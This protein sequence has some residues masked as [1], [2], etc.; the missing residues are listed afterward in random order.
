MQFPNIDPIA[1][2]LGPVSIHWYGLM[3]LVG[4]SVA[5]WLG[6]NRAKKKPQLGWTEDNVSDAIFYAAMGVI[7]GGRVGYML[8]YNFDGLLANPLSLFKLWEGGMSFH[9]GLIAC[10][11]LMWYFGHK[12]GKSFLQVT[13][14]MV[15]LGPIGIGAVRIANFINGELWGRTSD[16]P[17]AMV[18]PTGGPLAR[19]P[20]Q[21]YE[22]LLEG[23]LLFVV[24]WWF[25]GKQRPVGAASGLFLLWYGSARFII[26]F[27]RQPDAHMG[28]GGFMAMQWLTMGQI[29]STPMILFGAWLIW[30]AYQNAANPMQ[31]K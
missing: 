21:L 8:F 27:F 19:H 7:V 18:F 30:R 14:F 26:E 16:V 12:T 11:L 6:N 22:S 29:L 15:P 20:S 1:I 5:W 3:Y 17:W 31:A 9:G 4:F 24:L 23:W 13:D 2:S 28:E 10:I 25:S